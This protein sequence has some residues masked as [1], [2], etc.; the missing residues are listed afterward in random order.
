MTLRKSSWFTAAL[1]RIILACAVIFVAQW[2]M[3]LGIET[4]RH[5]IAWSRP[6]L[7]VGAG[8][9]TVLGSAGSAMAHASK[10]SLALPTLRLLSHGRSWRRGV[11][12]LASALGIASVAF[13]MMA[14]AR[15]YDPVS[16]SRSEDSGIDIMVVLDMSLSMN[17]ILDDSRGR[18][19]TKAD[20][21][22]HKP[23]RLDVAKEVIVDF[24]QKRP[25]DRIGGVVFGPDAYLLCPPTLDKRLFADL[26]SKLELGMISGAGTSIG[27]GVGTAVAR[28][29]HSTSPSKVI[30][31]LTDGDN[32]SGRYAPEYAARLAQGANVQLFTVQIGDGDW[33]EIEEGNDLAGHIRYGKVKFPVNPVLLEKMSGLAGGKS[34]VASKREELE[35]SMHSILNQLATTKFVTEDL[36]IVELFPHAVW[37][38]ACQLGLSTLCTLLVR[39]LL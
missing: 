27:D 29:R 25:H 1:I 31:L 12:A 30:I 39:R 23:T 36:K 10:A 19:I 16:E 5:D 24:A 2:L 32:T 18:R 9:I 8:A 22:E 38:A 34:F 28:L 37:F 20:G 13:C 15:P 11:E 26:V 4:P 35:A 17:A 33:A 6:W 14:L 7:L 21:L 3:F